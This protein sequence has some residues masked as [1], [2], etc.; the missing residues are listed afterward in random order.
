MSH[1]TSIIKRP[2][3]TEKA[4]WQAT[5][6]CTGGPRKGKTLNRYTFEVALLARKAEIK[7]AIEKQYGVKVEAVRVQIRKGETVRTRQGYAKKPS[8]KRA[9]VDLQPDCKIDLFS[10]PA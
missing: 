3:L 8:W 1:T 4:T 10:N 2:I 6:E 7:D 9:L 5:H